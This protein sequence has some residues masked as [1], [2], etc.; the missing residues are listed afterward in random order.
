[1]LITISRRAGIFQSVAE[2]Q[3]VLGEWYELLYEVPHCEAFSTPILILLFYFSF[4]LFYL[5]IYLFIYFFFDYVECLS[6]HL[7]KRN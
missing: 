6:K 4:I 1:M 5:F 2:V 7:Q 3:T